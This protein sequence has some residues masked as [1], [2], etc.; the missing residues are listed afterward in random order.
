MIL[1]AILTAIAINLIGAVIA[2]K[3]LDYIIKQKEWQDFVSKFYGMLTIKF[4][5]FVVVI[6]AIIKFSGFD[7]AA[8]ALSFVMSYFLAL[9]VE[10]LYINKRY[11]VIKFK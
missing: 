4:V 7:Q 8:F 3:R 5:I 1:A 2:I 11:S 9:I 10:I 6:V